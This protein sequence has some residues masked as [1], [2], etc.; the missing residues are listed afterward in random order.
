MSSLWFQLQNFHPHILSF[1]HIWWRRCVVWLD[2]KISGVVEMDG[3]EHKYVSLYESTEMLIILFQFFDLPEPTLSLTCDWASQ[4][5]SFFHKYVSLYE[6]ALKCCLLFFSSSTH[7]H[8]IAAMTQSRP[9]TT[10]FSVLIKK[11]IALDSPCRT[12]FEELIDRVW[13]RALWTN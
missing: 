9:K 6:S 11:L 12:Q 1:H 4:E 7:H 13:S 8:R 2:G 5:Q 10:E 3:R